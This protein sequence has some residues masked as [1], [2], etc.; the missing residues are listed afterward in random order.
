MCARVCECEC[1]RGGKNQLKEEER[2]IRKIL[3]LA[4]RPGVCMCECM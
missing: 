4:R 3:W 2:E 1:V